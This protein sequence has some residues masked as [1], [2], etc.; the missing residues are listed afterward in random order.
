MQHA[1]IHL[2]TA[3]GI[4]LETIHQGDWKDEINDRDRATIVAL[5]LILSGLILERLLPLALNAASSI[6]SR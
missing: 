4:R 3:D 2:E 6:P 5:W 1:R